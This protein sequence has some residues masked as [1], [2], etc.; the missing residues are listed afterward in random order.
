MLGR[1]PSP[2]AHLRPQ[3]LSGASTLQWTAHGARR[4][5]RTACASPPPAATAASATATSA[6]ANGASRC[7]AQRGRR[8]A[9][10]GGGGAVSR[11]RRRLLGRQPRGRGEGE[12]WGGL[13]GARRACAAARTWLAGPRGDAVARGAC[14]GAVEASARWRR[15]AA[16]AR[17]HAMVHE[18]APRRMRGRSAPSLPPRPPTVDVSTLT[19]GT[20]TAAP[21]GC[22]RRTALRP[23]DARAQ[24]A[25]ARRHTASCG[26]GGPCGSWRRR[27]C[28]WARSRGERGCRASPRGGWRG[29]GSWR[30]GWRKGGRW[31][32]IETSSKRHSYWA[33]PSHLALG[34]H[35]PSGPTALRHRPTP[36]LT[37]TLL[38]HRA[39]RGEGAQGRS[40]RRRGRREA[41]RVVR[42]AP[43]QWGPLRPCGARCWCAC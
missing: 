24:R 19:A 27:K 21:H 36:L 42:G 43:R 20:A 40:P 17:G 7:V 5:A 38:W 6:A 31:P 25:A 8:G 28:P 9:C 13:A 41:R 30:G 32:C 11:R 2:L 10:G 23:S 29:G 4:A 14:V 22:S 37:S 35:A 39:R 34:P 16:P 18:G 1:S 3:Q 33:I 15:H 12:S 26:G